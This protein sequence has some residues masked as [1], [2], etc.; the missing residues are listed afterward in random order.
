[1][2]SGDV[3]LITGTRTGIGRFLA[4]HFVRNGALVEGCSRSSPDW[5]LEGYT[6]HC[7]DVAD[8]AAVKSMFV[9]IQKRPWAPGYPSQQCRYRFDEPHHA[10]PPR[11][12]AE[13]NVHQFIWHL[14]DVP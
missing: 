8:E 6:H 4:E 7:L 10:H 14:P 12:A 13:N 3:V 11:N 1:M 2:S 5:E 9:D